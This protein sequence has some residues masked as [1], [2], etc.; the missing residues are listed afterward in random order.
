MNLA[1]GP[2]R[3]RCVVEDPVGIHE[4]KRTISE[5]QILGVALNEMSFETCQLKAPA[6][7]ADRRIGQVDRRVMGTGAHKSF[8]LTAASAADFEHSQAPG[9]FETYR[10]RQPR[11]HFVP[12]LVEASI[13]GWTSARL[14]SEP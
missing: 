5:G 2:R 14:I 12:V 7:Y 1:D 13:K 10:R 9:L 4:V 3:I 11:M 6:R 8:G